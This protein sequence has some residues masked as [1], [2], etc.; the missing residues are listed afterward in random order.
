M[1]VV[2]SSEIISSAMISDLHNPVGWQGI[3]SYFV[4]MSIWGRRG[5][6]KSIRQCGYRYE[7]DLERVMW[8]R[9]TDFP[10]SGLESRMMCPCCRSRRVVVRFD[11]PSLPNAMRAVR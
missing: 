9:G 8:T 5:G 11:V 4:L 6:I 1:I 10:L 7:L 3:C 2:V